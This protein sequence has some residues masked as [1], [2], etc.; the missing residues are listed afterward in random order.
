MKYHPSHISKTL[1]FHRDKTAVPEV[2]PFT[3]KH[4]VSNLAYPFS[5]SNSR[6]KV[7]SVEKIRYMECMVGERG[8]GGLALKGGHGYFLSIFVTCKH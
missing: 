7:S 6:S 3:C 1:D 4:S 8:L 2:E 5:K